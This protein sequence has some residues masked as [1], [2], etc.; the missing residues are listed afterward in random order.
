MTQNRAGR[1]GHRDI[2]STIVW[3]RRL[4]PNAHRVREARPVATQRAD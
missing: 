4:E 3:D 1:S 2:G